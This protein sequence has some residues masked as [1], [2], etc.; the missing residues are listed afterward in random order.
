MLFTEA[1]H[2]ENCDGK[3]QDVERCSG[4]PSKCPI[5]FAFWKKRETFYFKNYLKYFL[6]M[7]ER[8][9]E[10]RCFSPD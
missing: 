10:N 5:V 1:D 7:G 4:P 2:F 6:R 3:V 9:S 8:L